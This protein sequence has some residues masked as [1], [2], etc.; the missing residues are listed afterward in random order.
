MNSARK[1]HDKERKTKTLLEADGWLVVRAPASLGPCDLIALKAGE[2]PRL[3]E[4]KCNA[5]SPYMNFRATDR[6]RL[7]E[8]AKRAGAVAELV[9]WAPRAR[10]P[11]FID[12]ALWP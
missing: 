6:A 4:C 10:T 1:G 11:Q 8:V 3:L 7:R 2:R 5:G 9:F 12:E